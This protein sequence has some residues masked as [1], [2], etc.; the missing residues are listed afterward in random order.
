V[1]WIAIINTDPF[2]GRL[3]GFEAKRVRQLIYD[4]P[5]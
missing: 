4:L 2:P 5:R 3:K 1:R